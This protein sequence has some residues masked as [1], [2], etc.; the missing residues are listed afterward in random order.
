MLAITIYEESYCF[1]VKQM[2]QMRPTLWLETDS[3][4]A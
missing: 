1:I 3:V 4:F 2:R